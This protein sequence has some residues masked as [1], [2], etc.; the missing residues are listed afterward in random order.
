MKIEIQPTLKTELMLY[1]IR[2]NHI[3]ISSMLQEEIDNILPTI[4]EDIVEYLHNI[5]EIK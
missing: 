5:M 4:I 2:D 3:D 1:L